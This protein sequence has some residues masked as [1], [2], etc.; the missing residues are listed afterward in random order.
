VDID[1]SST[2][3]FQ[4]CK[5]NKTSTKES[6]KKGKTNERGSNKSSVK[7]NIEEECMKK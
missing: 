2:L 6:G 5:T 4:H 1:V 7:I 3:R